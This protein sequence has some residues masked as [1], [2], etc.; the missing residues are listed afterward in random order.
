MASKHTVHT[1][2][3]IVQNEKRVSAGVDQL[4]GEVCGCHQCA[5]D[6]AAL[7]DQLGYGPCVLWELRRSS[8]ELACLAPAPMHG[9]PSS[10]IHA[11]S[12]AFQSNAKGIMTNTH[13]TSA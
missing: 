13:P 7:T 1:K 3:R 2:T 11:G 8:V 9:S 10:F 5:A 6:W 12:V 4:L